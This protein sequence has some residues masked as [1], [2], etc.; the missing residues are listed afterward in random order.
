MLSSLTGAGIHTQFRGLKTLDKL[1][2]QAS[3]DAGLGKVISHQFSVQTP[4]GA[5]SGRWG[6]I[7]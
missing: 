7:E 2:I 6:K 1:R 3:Q 5:S 4:L